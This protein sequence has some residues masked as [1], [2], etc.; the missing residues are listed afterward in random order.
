MIAK[1]DD[2]MRPGVVSMTH[3]FGDLPEKGGYLA[4]GVSPNIFIPTRA[5]K[6]H[7]TI[8]A[9]P[10]MSNFPVHLAR[11]EGANA[12]AFA[13]AADDAPSTS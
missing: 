11:C 4:D 3:G 6:D 2:S 9:M 1:A 12:P 8:N 5:P 10:L 13:F 7:Q